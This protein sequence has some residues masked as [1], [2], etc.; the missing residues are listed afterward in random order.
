MVNLIDAVNTTG[1]TQVTQ[2]N[3]TLQVTVSGDQTEF[4]WMYTQDGIDYQAK[5]VMM[6]FENNILL[7]MTDGYFLFTVGT[8]QLS[9]SQSEAITMAK[10][11]VSTLIWNF[12]GTKYT[13]FPV[14]DTPISVQMVPHPRSDSDELIPYWY[15]ILG[16]DRVYPGGVD[17]VTVGIFADNGQIDGI[18][19][20]SA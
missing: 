10:N 20:L 12:N 7:T 2:G 9:I 15:V 6:T 13:S 19:M 18:Q 4:M 8:P 17:E 11:Y 16:L 14:L 3:M 5:G 1:P